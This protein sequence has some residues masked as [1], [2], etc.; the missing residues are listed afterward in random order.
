MAVDQIGASG[1]TIA[2]LSDRITTLTTGMQGIFGSDI[3]IDPDSPDGQLINIVCQMIQD[4]AELIMQSN[5]MFDPNQAIGTILDQRVAL[6]NIQRQAG[7]YTI[8]NIT[9]TV[10]SPVSLPGLDQTAQPVFTVSDNAGTQW[11]LIS[12]VNTGGAGSYI[13]AFQAASPGAITSVPNSITTIVT[14]V[15]GVTAVNNPTTYTTLGIN[16]ETD[17]ALKIRRQQSVA[18]GS[19]GYLASLLAALENISGVTYAK[20]FENNTGTTNG[21]GVTG[22]SIWAIVAGSAPSASIA[23]AIYNYRNGGCGMVGGQSFNITQADGSVFT[24]LWDTVASVN[25][26]TQFNI[27]SLDGVNAPKTAAV[28][29]ALASSLAPAPYGQVNINQLAA[30]VQAADSN[31]LVTNAGFSTATTQT[32]N[33]SAIA[34]SG[35]FKINYSTGVSAAIN[36]NDS[37]ATIQTK[38]RA[39]AGL[40]SATVTGSIATQSLVIALGLTTSAGLLYVTSNSLLTAGSAAITFTYSESYANTLTPAAKNYQFAVV[41]GNIVIL[42]MY[43]T[44]PNGVTAVSSGNVVVTLSIAHGAKTAQFSAVGGYGT[45]SFAVTTSVG[46]T[47]NSSGLYTSG[48]SSGSDTVTITDLLGNSCTCAVTLT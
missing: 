42:P 37:A 28:Q 11:Q 45:Y 6:N 25:L 40:A 35:T 15:L 23:Q 48:T 46:S 2:A 29:S 10:S 41:Q 16:E 1:L 30:L 21:D 26:F 14:I 5:A 18:I 3:N 33:L 13:Y 4:T 22:H 17:A 7:T 38:I 20:V 36:W 44:V 19:Q 43:A 39:V 8:T 12:S 31:S 24:V 47:I 34:A 9:V 27:S 32:L